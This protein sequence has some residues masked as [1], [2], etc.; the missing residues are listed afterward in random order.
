MR[1]LTVEV[2]LYKFNEL[3]E[4]AKETAINNEIQFMLDVYD[5]ESEYVSDE[6]KRAIKKADAMQTP[7]FAGAYIWEYCKDEVIANLMEYEF[8]DNGKIFCL[9]D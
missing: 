1:T 2:K 7:W 6:Y 3:S 5:V 9:P 8:T 4:K